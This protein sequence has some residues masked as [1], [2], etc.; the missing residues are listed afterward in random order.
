MRWPQMR[1]PSFG[2]TAVAAAFTLAMQLEVWVWW[3]EA[4]QGPRPLAATFGLLL[5]AALA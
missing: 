5:T 2:D 4:E 1:R 3:T